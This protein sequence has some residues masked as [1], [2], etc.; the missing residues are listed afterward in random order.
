MN[1]SRYFLS[2]ALIAGL[3]LSGCGG[4]SGIS[5]CPP[6]QYPDEKVGEELKKV[7][8][9]GFEDFWAWMGGVEKLNQALEVC[10]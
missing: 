9:E 4:G 6:P 1:S 7:P 10:Q 8:Y 3:F 5:K 2:L